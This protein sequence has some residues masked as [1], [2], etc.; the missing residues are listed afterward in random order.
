MLLQPANTIPVP[1][2]KARI[3]ALTENAFLRYFSFAILYVAQGIPEGM[4]FFG[5]PAWLAMNGKTPAQIG[6]YAGVMALPWSFKILVAPLMDRFTFLPMGRRRPWVLVGQFGLMASFIFMAFISHPLDNLNVLMASAFCIS[7]FGAF[8]DV[9]V[10]GMAIDVVPLDQQARA[11]GVMWGAKTI[12][13]S[14]SLVTGTWMI[15]HVSFHYAI[16]SLSVAVCLIMLVP[17]MV[18]ERP[19]EKMLPWTK[20][21]TS[22]FAAKIQLENFAEIFKSLFRVFLLPSS[23]FL[24]VVFF[25]IQIAFGLMDTLLPVFTIQG[26]GWTNA[27]YSSV[28][29]VVNIGSGFLGMIAGGLLADKFGKR[30]MMSIYLSVF[31]ILVT[32]MFLLKMFW[33]RDILV[34]AFIGIYCLIYVFFCIGAFATGMELCWRRVAA[35]QFTLYMAIS[36]LGRAIGAGLLGRL[37]AHLSW[38]YVILTEAAFA[39]I[40]ILLLQ[41]IRVHHHVSRVSLLEHKMQ[42]Q[43]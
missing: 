35:T 8:Q 29:S 2:G 41:F 20:G 37:H 15:N 42:E 16:I 38:E 43:H 24:G 27:E 1:V 3:P 36:N 22:P 39:I 9:A 30:K 5:I 21:I 7:F 19:G 40:A 12:G 28:Y 32:A 14:I 34:E 11:N 31:A 4:T 13:T 33:H 25:V 23:F 18:R 10:D 26:V 17:I 6:T